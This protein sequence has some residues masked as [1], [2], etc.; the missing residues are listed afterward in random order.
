MHLLEVSPSDVRVLYLPEVHKAI[1]VASLWLWGVEGG[2][3]EGGVGRGGAGWR[4]G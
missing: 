2:R 3:G 1:V 4:E